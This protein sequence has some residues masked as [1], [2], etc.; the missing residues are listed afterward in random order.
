MKLSSFFD[1]NEAL[2]NKSGT[3]ED[4]LFAI[5]AF[6]SAHYNEPL[7]SER[8]CDVCGL[9][10]SQLRRRYKEKFGVSPM[11]YMHLLRCNIGAQLLLHT[12]MPIGQISEKIGY[13]DSS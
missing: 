10:A 1:K 4:I 9:S 12:S 3:T 11:K 7:T 2:I 5:E 8:L 13:F 6:I